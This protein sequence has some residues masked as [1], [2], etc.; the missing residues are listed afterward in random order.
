MD[1]LLELKGQGHTLAV[2]T[3]KSRRGLARIFDHMNLEDFFAAS[4]CADE[5]RS[6]PHPLMLE[7]ILA[8]LAVPREDA[9]MIGDTDFDLIMAKAAKVKAVGVT[10][11]AHPVERL[12]RA[13]PDLLVDELS[14]LLV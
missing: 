7:E 2:A 1:V 14:Q 12:E 5:T 3:G 8:E 13:L 4:R 11:G 10:Y 6:K 9:V